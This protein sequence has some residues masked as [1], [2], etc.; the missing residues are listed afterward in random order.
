MKLHLVFELKK[1]FSVSNLI[2]LAPK[3]EQ[4]YCGYT[5]LSVKL[6]RRLVNEIDLAL[7]HGYVNTFVRD[8]DP[9]PSRASD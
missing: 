2:D 3:L 1:R 6:R 9:P 4:M 8:G 7:Q 5:L